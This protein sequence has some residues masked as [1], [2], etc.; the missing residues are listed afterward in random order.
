MRTPSAFTHASPHAGIRGAVRHA[1]ISSSKAAVKQAL[2]LLLYCC[3]PDASSYRRSLHISVM[4][5][6]DSVFFW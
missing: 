1:G 6:P 5:T 4:P 2:S 3:P